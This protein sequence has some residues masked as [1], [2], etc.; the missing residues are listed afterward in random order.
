MAT[1][2][3]DDRAEK[4]PL[5]TAGS[6]FYPTFL[7]RGLLVCRGFRERLLADPSFFV[8]L[9]I[10]VRQAS[11]LVCPSLPTKKRNCYSV[12]PLLINLNDGQIHVTLRSLQNQKF[13]TDTKCCAREGE[14]LPATE[15]C[16]VGQGATRCICATLNNGRA[17]LTCCQ[18]GYAVLH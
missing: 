5:L 3:S 13:A 1:S 9:G 4:A 11:C 14:Q 6:L 12:W 16:D 7:V 18:N 15:I 8:K 2:G 17:E 10:E